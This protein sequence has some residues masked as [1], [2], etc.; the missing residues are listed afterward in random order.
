MTT[1]ASSTLPGRR[2]SG[3]S[4]AV[5][6]VRGAIASSSV[7]AR[8]TAAAVL[9]SLGVAVW[10][11]TQDTTVPDFYSAVQTRYAFITHDEIARG[12]LASPFIDFGLYNYPP[13]GRLIGAVGTFVGGVNIKAVMLALDVVFLPALAIGCY[14]VGRRLGGTRAG[15]LAALFA[16]GAPI[17]VSESHEVYL[18]PLQAGMVALSVLAIV[19]SRRFER[20]GV[21]A[22]AGVA[23]GLAFLTKETTPIFLGGLIAVVLL[24][25]GWRN[26]RGLS[27][28][29]ATVIVIASPWYLYHFSRLKQLTGQVNN[30]P[31]HPIAESV[32]A[33][34]SFENATWYFWDAANIQLRAALLVL[35]IVGIVL[36]VRV[37][38]RDRRPD[39]IYPELLGGLLVSYVGMTLIA[40]KDPRY[41]LPALVYMAVLGTSWIPKLKGLL[42]P[43]L[44]AALLAAVAATFISVPFGAGGRNYALRASLPGAYPEKTNGDRFITFYA[45]T[46]WI[47]GPPDSGDGN[48]LALMRGLRSHG[49]RAFAACCAKGERPEGAVE[50][51]ANRIDFNVSGL[52]VTGRE[53]GLHYLEQQGEIQSNDV[54]LAAYPPIPG[55]PPC[56]R[57]RDGT[58]IYAILGDPFGRPVSRYT[59]IC[60]GRTPAVYGYQ[61]G[62]VPANIRR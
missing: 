16:L 9:F 46:G 35:L 15:L 8:L 45:T 1:Q 31:P 20:V 38:I 50:G 40:I 62:Q 56:Q 47:A 27:A 51:N 11:V 29:A 49:V 59:F 30:P 33:H 36:A 25:G 21:A 60:P 22:L 37:A 17:I 52:V 10:W 55:A 42:R 14:G 7:D 58:G 61:A 13:L 18:D 12:A 48:V 24:R 32:P 6:R 28:W 43:A 57:L 2:E 44:T 4:I 53:A 26:W 34:V 54:F 41:D 5:A 19:A 23:T 3:W 39:N